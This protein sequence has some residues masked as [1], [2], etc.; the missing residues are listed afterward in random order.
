MP[1]TPSHAVVALPFIRTPLVPG[2][3]AV[4]AMT[5]DLPLFLPR[6]LRGA[7]PYEVFHTYAF[8]P[9]TAV[10]A[11]VLFL[12]WRFVLRPAVRALAPT[13]LARRLPA[14]WDRPA[15]ATAQETFVGRRGAVATTMVLLLSLALGVASHILWD[16]FTHEGRAGVAL[17][18][19]LDAMWG[20][21]PGY[22]WLQYGSGVGGLAVLGIW[23]LGRLRRA[24]KT[25]VD[26]VVTPALRW[27]WIAALPV[28]LI[29]AWLVGL[30]VWGGFT[31]DYTYRHLAYR[32]LPQA[33]GIWGAL[34]LAL[35]AAVSMLRRRRT[36][37]VNGA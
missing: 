37:A 6:V 12:V 2:A 30:A 26:A 22:K 29:G 25:P 4:G 20:P 9:V 35:C 15:A 31:D 17:M 3:I 24:P 23:A 14:A 10:L 27:T 34:T 5:P 33:S 21:L 28:L 8:V 18:P 16:S 36:G 1:F 7:L 19:A 11:L 32:T 13:A